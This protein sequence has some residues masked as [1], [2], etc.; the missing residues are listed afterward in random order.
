MSCRHESL[1]QLKSDEMNIIYG[2]DVTKL[3]NML[4]E[5]IFMM[6]SLCN[7]CIYLPL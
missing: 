5:I 2:F 4:S 7:T 1:N 6:V 3:H